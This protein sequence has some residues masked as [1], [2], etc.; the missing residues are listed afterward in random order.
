M[1]NR[2]SD[3][4]INTGHDVSPKPD[5]QK[6]QDEPRRTPA[7][8][9]AMTVR[10]SLEGLWKFK[11]LLRLLI[12]IPIKHCKGSLWISLPHLF[13]MILNCVKLALITKLAFSVGAC[14]SKLSS[15]IIHGHLTLRHALLQGWE[16][17]YETPPYPASIG[18]F[19]LYSIDDFK[20][21]INFSVA[22][23]YN[24][25]TD[26]TGI[27][28][29]LS[30]DTL[31]LELNYFQINDN[32]EIVAKNIMYA[33]GPGLT[34][35]T[36]NGVIKYSYN[37]TEDLR[38]LNLDD[39]FRRVL[40]VNIRSS[41]HS[42][43]VSFNEKRVTCFAIAINVSFEDNDHNGQV[44]IDMQTNTIPI[45]CGKM[46]LTV[47]ENEHLCPKLKQT[48][49]NTCL[50]FTFATVAVDS[51]YFVISLAVLVFLRAFWAQRNGFE[52]TKLSYLF[53]FWLIFC[54]T[55]DVFILIGTLDLKYAMNDHRETVALPSYDELAFHIGMG[56]LLG[57]I[58]ILRFLKINIKFSLLF[59]T[60]YY[61]FWNVFAFI[62]CA[63]VLFVGFFACAY[64]SL[65]VYHVKFASQ[66]SSAETLF[67][68]IN[69][70][71]VYNTFA[72]LDDRLAGD[73][74]TVKLHR[75]IIVY[76]FVILFTIIMLNLIIAL[77]NSA[78]ENVMQKE[79]NE[80]D[81]DAFLSLTVLNAAT[82]VPLFAYLNYDAIKST[83]TSSLGCV[84]CCNL[85]SKCLAKLL[86]GGEMRHLR[87]YIKDC[88]FLR[89]WIEEKQE[90]PE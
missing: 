3:T 65:G 42:F 81:I 55:G 51:I 79:K 19:A 10:E 78:Y 21:R 90:E 80:D 26:I 58:S 62:V 67:S 71:D 6:N 43:R 54:V 30:H 64:V 74:K 17:S 70:D 45:N 49:L 9:K 63:G 12:F 86:L 4:L 50:V 48:L 24:I 27:F 57:W 56:C 35:K 72:S 7:Y 61:S 69:G 60:L 59:H 20:K 31:S 34:N 37:V 41:L 85:Q 16:A 88:L 11:L 84:C 5:A 33:P 68:L 77:F 76:S 38:Y 23:Y 89:I 15:D 39:V 52:L 87:W 13:W 75:N 46:N 47:P 18:T 8:E 44:C 28:Q 14:R 29:R 83:H 25:H 53:K 40:N 1:A 82:K 22:Q 73:Q 66:E 2:E 32:N 36:E